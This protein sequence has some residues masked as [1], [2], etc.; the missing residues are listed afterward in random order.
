M[1]GATQYPEREAAPSLGG[2]DRSG[3]RKLKIDFQLFSGETLAT[4]SLL[5]FRKIKRS[6]KNSLFVSVKG[7]LNI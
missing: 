5:A 4:T 7:K 3:R 6:L 1:E 2:T